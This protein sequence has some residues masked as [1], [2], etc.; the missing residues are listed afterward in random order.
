MNIDVPD[1]P[2]GE[3]LPTPRYLFWKPR[4]RRRHWR[5]VIDWNGCECTYYWHY[6][7]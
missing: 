3:W 5:W 2:V 6:S 7:R 4:N 1:H